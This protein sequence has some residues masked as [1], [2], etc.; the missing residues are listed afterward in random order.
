VDGAVPHSL[1]DVE[2]GKAIGTE[3]EPVA[4]AVTVTVTEGVVS[5]P[6]PSP[7]GSKLTFLEF[8]RLY[9]WCYEKNFAGKRL[10]TILAGKW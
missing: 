6:K 9:V 5:I 4:V 3:A 2:A 10:V 7:T 8:A 1:L